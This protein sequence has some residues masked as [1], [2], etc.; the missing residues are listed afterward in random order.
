MR[1]LRSIQ[2]WLLKPVL[3]DHPHAQH[4]AVI[5]DLLDSH[6]EIAQLAHDDLTR[7]RDSDKGRKGMSG[8]QAVRILLLKK[9]HRLSYREL[10]F[11][12]QDS[13]AFR[14]FVCAP[15]RDPWAWTTL[16]SNIKR[17]RPETLER[18]NQLLLK[19]AKAAGIENGSKARTDCT[20]VESNI[21]PPTDSSLLCDG[22]RV[23]T[24]LL[25]RAR[26]KVPSA[27][28]AFTD[29]HRR[30]RRRL[31]A[32]TFPAKGKKRGAHLRR[33]YQD[34]LKVS[35][36]TLGYARAALER[37]KPENL[38]SSS[39]VA[40]RSIAEDLSRELERYVELMARV[41]TQTTRRVID[42][43]QVPANEKILSLFETHTDVIVKGERDVVFGHKVCLTAGASSL[44]LDCFI[45]P[46][47]PADSTLVRP[48]L[49][50]QVDIYGQGPRQVSFDGAFAS[51]ENLRLAKDEFGVED[52]AFHK[53]SG[54]KIED[55]ARSPWVYRR[56]RNF[57]SGIEGL[58]SGLKSG[59]MDRCRWR[60]QDT[61]ESFR[62]YVWACVLAFNVA[63]LARKLAPQST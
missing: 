36:K 62:S 14:G 17:L 2:A 43:E 11:H 27:G 33:N 50:R 55:M 37:L 5:A 28:V 9:M 51:Q 6:P 60:S 21:H 12:L 52:V 24:R 34:L 16:Q 40:E 57:R 4:L 54:L 1:V 7:D 29:H 41:I 42:G 47:N 39:G 20:A 32:I 56:L 8:D 45:E 26:A 58:I 10:E 25:V 30:A 38:P 22:V 59:G 49:Q 3:G 31:Q 35:R 19:T 23:L 63:V 48:A 18:I 15:R 61:L 13:T 46:G 53:K 44:I